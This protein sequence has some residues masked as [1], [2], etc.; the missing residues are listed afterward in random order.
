MNR[1]FIKSF[2]SFQVF[3][4]GEDRPNYIHR[5]CNQLDDSQWQWFYEQM[6]EPVAFVTDITYLFYVLKWILKYDFDDL[7]YAVYFQD[8]MNPECIPQS[9]IKDEWLAKL[10]DRYEQRLK[11]ELSEIHY[12][13][14][15][16]IDDDA[17]IF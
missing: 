12:S 1:N 17:G 11:K 7:S 8:I 6:L 2:D 3:M 10:L 13:S 15:V 9:Q 14:N 5:Y 4:L 16:T